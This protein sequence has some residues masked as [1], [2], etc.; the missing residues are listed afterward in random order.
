[1]MA[2]PA[3]ALQA[4]MSLMGTTMIALGR[5][6]VQLRSAAESTVVLLTF[7]L[8]AS[9]FGL[10]WTAYVCF[11]AVIL[12]W[13]RQLALNLPALECSPL[14]FA[15]CLAV[16]AIMTIGAALVY[17]YAVAGRELGNW[18]HAFIAAGI[19]AIALLLSVLLQ[20]RVLRESVH[21]LRAT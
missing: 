9:H 10:L 18:N 21:K 13:P 6:D 1:M 20:L 4:V 3:A 16:P 17:D 15:R 11:A 14:L 12:Y 5:A 7:I 8:V 19:G 2:M